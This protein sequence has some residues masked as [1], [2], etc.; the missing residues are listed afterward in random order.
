MGNQKPTDFIPRLCHV[1]FVAS[2][3]VN[4]NSC[5]VWQ[6][7]IT[8]LKELNLER[9][10]R[11]VAYLSP[12]L[13]RNIHSSVYIKILALIFMYIKNSYYTVKQPC[14]KVVSYTKI[15]S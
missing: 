3:Y 10:F 1:I 15:F 14:Y 5:S 11:Y 6:L 9:N 8:F 4:F 12:S 2:L 7:K 13:F